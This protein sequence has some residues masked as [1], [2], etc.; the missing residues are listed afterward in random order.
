MPTKARYGY[1][2]G[3]ANVGVTLMNLVTQNGIACTPGSINGITRTTWQENGGNPLAIEADTA[4][5]VAN[6]LF[7]SIQGA[8]GSDPK[9][10]TDLIGYNFLDV[11]PPTS[12]PAKD[13]YTV[14][15]AFTP[16]LGQPFAVPWKVV[17]LS[18]ANA[19]PTA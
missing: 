3:F 11:V 9:W 7:A 19:I 16:A 13:R 6:T 15:Y 10:K 8:N 17:I 12:F 5:V 18:N 2:E 4:L 1:V 14:S